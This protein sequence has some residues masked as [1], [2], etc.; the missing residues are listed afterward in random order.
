[1]VFLVLERFRS[2]LSQVFFQDNSVTG[3]AFVHCICEVPY[4]W[5]EADD[6]V[7][8]HVDHHCR[9]KACWKPS[10]DVA[11]RFHN[12]KGK[13]GIKYIADTSETLAAEQTLGFGSKLTMESAQSHCS[14]RIEFHIS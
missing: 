14:N 6:E 10:V 7:N 5:D 9:S 3:V 11:A 4:K 12:H 2:L 1:M 13:Q 8:D